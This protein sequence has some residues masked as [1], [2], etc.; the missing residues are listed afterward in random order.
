[1]KNGGDAGG[2]RGKW[3]ALAGGVVGVLV[4]VGAASWMDIAVGRLVWWLVVLGVALVGAIIGKASEAI[5]EE[6]E[7]PAEIPKNYNEEKENIRDCDL[8]LFKGNYRTSRLF[9]KLNLSFYSHAAFVLRWG[10]RLMVLQAEGKGIETIPLSVCIGEY[11]GRVDWYKLKYGELENWGVQNIDDALALV[12]AEGR[13]DL[14]MKY[15]YIAL[16]KNL[17]QWAFNVKLLDPVSPKGM[18]CSQYVAH[19]FSRAG[20][21]IGKSGEEDEADFLRRLGGNKRWYESPK[22]SQRGKL[23]GFPMRMV[24]SLRKKSRADIATFPKHI[25]NS[26]YVEYQCTFEHDINNV[27]DRRNDT[28]RADRALTAAL[29][30]AQRQKSFAVGQG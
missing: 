19:C 24:A 2:R 22:M 8:F 26:M 29:T 27:A 14:G 17:S 16:L 21:P 12:A 30:T 18:F 5:W 28:V 1:M 20:I 4:G 13:A 10:G 15:G 9:S 7:G 25:A 6:P 3:L 23:L 11:P